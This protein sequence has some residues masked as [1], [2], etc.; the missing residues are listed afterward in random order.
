MKTH[1]QMVTEWM[2][3]PAFKMAYDA[4]EP[5]FSLFDE[6]LKARH[7]AGLTQAEVAQRM[8]SKVSAV[9]RLESSGGNQKH[10]PSVATLRRYAE[11]VGCQVEIRLVRKAI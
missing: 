6:L 4:L 9:V 11:A 1:D 3:D 8:G 5:E 2:K 10:S 7:A